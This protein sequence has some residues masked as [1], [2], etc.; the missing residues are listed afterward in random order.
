MRLV[1]LVP[2]RVFICAAVLP[3]APLGL[4]LILAAS[5]SAQKPKI[6]PLPTPSKTAKTPV[7][8]PRQTAAQSHA[9]RLA[10]PKLM[11]AALGAIKENQ[12]A[13]LKYCYVLLASANNDYNG[14][15]TRALHE[16]HHAL[17]TLGASATGLQQHIDALRARDA[18]LAKNLAAG[19]GVNV[20]Q[21]LSDAQ[22]AHARHML[23]RLSLGLAE[24]G[25]VKVDVPVKRAVHEINEALRVAAGNALK[26]QEANML[27]RAYILLSA[28][29]H[30]YAGH[31][32]RAKRQVEEALNVLDAKILVGG[33]VAENI[34]AMRERDIATLAA[35][36]EQE[37]PTLH[38]P[39]VVSDV[40]MLMADVMI[41]QVWLLMEGAPNV[42][43]IRVRLRDAD[44]EIRL[45]MTVN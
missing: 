38:E 19:M 31:R 21:N 9:Q 5:A 43:L 4:V 24:N 25:Q 35:L 14:H 39:Q 16:I 44:R 22:L 27:A 10:L 34:K 7:T 12:A 42:G 2:L 8:S 13:V 11:Q 30:D 41:R 17:G 23:I 15:K 6:R 28:A 45:G 1:R 33:T 18:V 36:K 37:D 20:S 26:G 29:N 3:A 40:Q 32:A